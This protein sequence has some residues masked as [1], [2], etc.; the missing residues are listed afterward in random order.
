MFVNKCHIQISCG[1]WGTSGHSSTHIQVLRISGAPIA[2]ISFLV[3]P[4]KLLRLDEVDNM[5]DVDGWDRNRIVLFLQLTFQG[6]L[7]FFCLLQ[8]V[9]E[10]WRSEQLEVQVVAVSTNT[11]K[12]TR[13]VLLCV[14]DILFNSD[15]CDFG[16]LHQWHG[17]ALAK[18]T[19][20]SCFS[21]SSNCCC[22]CW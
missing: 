15:G 18:Y 12:N 14:V 19:S 10:T 2:P 22:S 21:A 16:R 20:F 1:L 3:S 5:H 4:D 8:L 9:L 11:L 7:P 13:N 6:K 17:S